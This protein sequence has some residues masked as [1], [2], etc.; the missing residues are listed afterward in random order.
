MSCESHVNSG[1]VSIGFA[2]TSFLLSE[3]KAPVIRGTS[4]YKIIDGPSWTEAEA[5]SAKLGGN[6]VTI[7]D[8]EE[9]LW[10]LDNIWSG[11]LWIG[12][13]DKDEEGVWQWSS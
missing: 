11:A 13:T 4:F 12:L 5:N 7:D 2:M 8:A 10:I 6:L 1:L 3:A 9:N